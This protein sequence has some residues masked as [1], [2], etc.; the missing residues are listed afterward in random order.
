MHNYQLTRTV[1]SV[2][3]A[4]VASM[5]ISVAQAAITLNPAALVDHGSYITDTLNHRDWYKFSNADS[6]VGLSYNAA[7]AQFSPLGWSAAS[8]AQ[9]QDL[10]SL[11][12]WTVDTPNDVFNINYGLTYGLQ[13]YLG[14]TGVFFFPGNEVGAVVRTTS[15]YGM[16][17]NTVFSSH[18]V[19]QSETQELFDAH[20]QGG[21][22]VG[23]RVDGFADLV[24][25]NS[26]N[27]SYGTWLTR[28]SSQ[29]PGCSRLAPVDC[30]N[31]VPEPASLAL[32][33]LGLVGLVAQRRR[34]LGG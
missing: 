34:Y 30:P 32:M 3:I 14:D 7:I 9:V 29:D 11:F 4:A 26:T 15:I 21:F 23:D 10:E 8:I 28:A 12:G 22:F 1:L 25:P 27:N 16:T 19:T 18:Y 17:S 13:A 6:T 20:G 24:S 33:A 5:S 2:A 31:N